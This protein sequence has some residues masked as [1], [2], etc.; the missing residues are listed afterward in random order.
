MLWKI[1]SPYVIIL[2]TM[3]WLLRMKKGGLYKVSTFHKSQTGQVI[4][5]DDYITRGNDPERNQQFE[6]IGYPIVSMSYDFRD[7]CCD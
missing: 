1:N 7:F 6:A 2:S 5:G 4:T 3:Q